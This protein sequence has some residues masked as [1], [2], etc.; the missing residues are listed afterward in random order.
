MFTGSPPHLVA[1]PT[2]RVDVLAAARASLL[3]VKHRSAAAAANT[4]KGKH[5]ESVTQNVP[6]WRDDRKGFLK[7]QRLVF[8]VISVC[9]RRCEEQS[10]QEQNHRRT[11]AA[12][13]HAVIREQQLAPALEGSSKLLEAQAQI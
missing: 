6:A 10:S 4:E 11:A 8:R 5:Q 7:E 9:W 1:P 12:C 13:K 2:P 3:G